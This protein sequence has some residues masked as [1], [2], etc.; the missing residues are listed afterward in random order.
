MLPL[1][2]FLRSHRH[3]AALILALALALRALVPAGYMVGSPAASGT[4]FLTIE[5]CADV[6][7]QRVTRQIAIGQ[8]APTGDHQPAANQRGDHPCAFS[9]LTMAALA[10]A[11]VVLL[12]AALAFVLALGF[13][14]VASPARPGT[15][16]LRPPLRGPPALA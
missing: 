16:R 6:L 10:G 11:D 8:S 13:A 9:T 3:M 2:I 1:R 5:I 14:P 7:G 4:R 15:P 12:A